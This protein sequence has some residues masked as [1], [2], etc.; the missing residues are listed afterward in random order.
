VGGGN[1]VDSS[2]GRIDRLWRSSSD[3]VHW[4]PP[5][6]TLYAPIHHARS[7]HPPPHPHTL[8]APPHPHRFP[9]PHTFPAPHT[10]TPPP[11]TATYYPRYARLALLCLGMPTA[12]TWLPWFS[13]PSPACA[14]CALAGRRDTFLASGLLASTQ[15][16]RAARQA[17]VATLATA[18]SGG[19]QTHPA[20]DINRDALARA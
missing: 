19:Y 5:L 8:H 13:S 6:H 14:C 12:A 3:Q 16:W 11:T 18:T 9:T 1:P 4:P 17:G 7:H 20:S 10:T 15:G 2:S